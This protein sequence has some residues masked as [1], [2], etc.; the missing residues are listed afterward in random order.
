MWRLVFA[1]SVVS[2]VAGCVPIR[3]SVQFDSFPQRFDAIQV[4]QVDGTVNG[5]PLKKEFLASVRRDRENVEMVFMD[6]L[7]QKALLK[8]A[9]GDGQYTVTPLVRGVTLPFSGEEIVDTARAV[10]LWQGTLDEH[11]SAEFHTVRFLVKIRDVGGD[12]TCLLPRVTELQP[13]VPDAP[14]LTIT[15][16]EWTC[17]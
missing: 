3:R 15:T 2:A 16:K 9:Y 7:W 10:F 4:V 12:G 11:G 6:P 17:R 14:R 13:R 8:V 5:A 1:I